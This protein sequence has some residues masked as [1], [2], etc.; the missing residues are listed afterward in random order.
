MYRFCLLLFFGLQAA[1]C[2]AQNIATDS[3]TAT[4]QVD[5][6]LKAADDFIAKRDL[7]NALATSSSAERLASEKFGRESLKFAE[8]CD[9]Q[10]WVHECR[11]EY[12]DA[13]KKY[14]ESISIIEKKLGKN[15]FEVAKRLNNL[16]NFYRN[17]GEYSKAEAMY[18]DAMQSMGNVFGFEHPNYARVV[19]N[20]AILY[21]NMGLFDKAETNF[22]HAKN[23]RVAAQG[24]DNIDYAGSLVNLGSLYTQFG[25]YEKGEECLK[26]AK[27]IFVDKLKMTQHPFYMNCVNNLGALY[28]QMGNYE[29]AEPM[30][31]EALEIAAKTSGRI[32]AGYA[33]S[34]NNLS[35]LYREVGSFEKAERLML[36]TKSIW[37]DVH[38]KEHIEYANCLSNLADFYL[39]TGAF[40]KAAL[41]LEEAQP[42]ILNV[43][44][45]EHEIYVRTLG[46]LANL[47]ATL[48]DRSRAET[49]RLASLQ[50][51][52]KL[53]GKEHDSYLKSLYNLGM[54]YMNSQNYGKAEEC[55]REAL[56]IGEKMFGQDCRDC[57]SALQNLATL[58]ELKNE[59]AEADRFHE[60]SFDGA[61]AQLEKATTFL[62]E[63]EIG[64][65]AQKFQG[66]ADHLNASLLA[67]P[68]SSPGK[69]AEISFDNALFFKGFVQ[70]S[71]IRLKQLSAVGTE[72]TNIS[73]QLKNTRRRLA[74][75]YAKPIAERTSV[76]EL[77]EKANAAEK[78]LA[79]TVKGYA[80][81]SR[82]V[83]WQEVK[84]ALRPGEVAIEFVHFRVNFPNATDSVM[85]AALLLAAGSERPVFVPL[86]EE[87]ELDALL[88]T[89]GARKSD[90][91]NRVYGAQAAGGKILHQLLWQPLE[92]SL[93]PGITTIYFSPSGL[94]HRL[95]LVAIPLSEGVTLA[96]RFQFVQLGSTRQLL[97]TNATGPDSGGE[98]A[99]FGGAQFDMDEAAISKA[100]AGFAARSADGTRGEVAFS[101]TDSTAR[102]GGDW[103]YLSWTEKEVDALQKI[104]TSAGEKTALFKGFAAT[105]EAFKSQSSPRILHLATHGY[106]F[107]EKSGPSSSTGGAQG[108]ASF[109][110]SEHPMIR[111][112]LILAGGNH[113][114]K[115]GR[116]YKPQMEDGVLTAYEIAQMDLSATELVVLSACETGLGDIQSS[117][118][119]YGLQRAFKIA[120][121]RHLIM[122]LWQVPDFQTQ[123]LMALFYKNYL[124]EKMPLPDAFRAAQK[125]MRERYEHPYFWAG[126][127]LLE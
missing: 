65:Y 106:F 15:H 18:F 40:Q 7:G 24:K 45:K 95:N 31:L 35:I 89:S 72:S 43:V 30:Y 51:M 28:W 122:S 21:W 6:L 59:H 66:Q 33:R 111:S 19:N 12:P 13:A 83:R 80:E 57:V 112:G 77:E 78:E 26:E 74:A 62:S 104:L 25:L 98:A 115:T 53:F 124:T 81:N 44:G 17:T 36:E 2:L 127:V 56:A 82:Q 46:V 48:G 55:F 42:I 11:K 96:D 110:M 68:M 23:I 125:V 54:L 117:E 87:K 75:E 94:L 47:Q 88:K 20:L 37:E 34:L 76:A 126:F 97:E 108:E 60:A 121:A 114:W 32:S 116:P 50:I 86:F 101:K 85:Y 69:L 109:K 4:R 63:R 16:A 71:A 5:S 91:V 107:P 123:E 103:A 100:N 118:G 52:E 38:G 14:L 41:L 29:N 1:F 10:G 3:L 79:R 70:L 73:G 120:G 39:Q 92:K 90:Y 49:L 84:N 22:L 8:V 113:A 99:L 9:K 27:G 105:E 64:K 93:P 102:G 119:V 58:H 67:R 61:F